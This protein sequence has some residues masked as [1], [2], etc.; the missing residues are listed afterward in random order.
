M[1]GKNDPAVAAAI[2]DARAFIDAILASDWQEL[3]ISGDDFE[4]FLAR[5][6]GGPNP[7]FT[8]IDSSASPASAATTQVT[9][10]AAPHVATIAW[11]A[12]P[13]TVFAAGKPLARLSVLD[14][15]T[16][17]RASNDGRVAGVD[18]AVGEL[19]EFGITI[20]QIAAEE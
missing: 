16:E 8:A 7:M 10:I 2:D 11:V 4:L 13:G 20:L 15:V 5:D 1:S 18:V 6:G 14:E 17:I 9:V 3:H 19:V 12:E